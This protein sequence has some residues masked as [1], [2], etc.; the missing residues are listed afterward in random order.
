MEEQVF[1][2]S[3]T[4]DK[5]EQISKRRKAAHAKMVSLKSGVYQ[6]FLGMEKAPYCDGALPKKSKELIAV[7]ISIA[8]DCELCMQWHIEQAA[9]DDATM[10][11]Q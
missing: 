6:R 3:W 1:T 11:E 7:G 5:L 4:T 2:R 9:K 8:T 10:E